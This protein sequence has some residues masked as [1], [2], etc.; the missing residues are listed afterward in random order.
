MTKL[1][2]FAGVAL[3]ALTIGV[4]GCGDDDDPVAPT[5]TVTVPTPPTP[6]PPPLAATMSPDA[7]TIGVGGT[8]VFAV[9]VSG[10]VAGE[11]ASWTCASSD[12]SKA[13]VSVIPVGCQATAVAVGGT[14]ITA[15][16]TKGGETTNAGAGLTITEDMVESAFMALALIEDSDDDAEVL[17]G[18]VSVT[19]NVERGD[20]TLM[21]LSVL[22]DGVVA[23][24]LPF[25]DI[26]AVA[27]PQD[28][29]AQQQAVHAFVLSFN[30]AEY[31]A[32]TGEPAY[33]NGERT[34]SAEL[35]VAGKDEPYRSGAHARE[36]DNDDGYVVMADLGDNSEI[37]D[38][39][40][41]W[42]GGPDNGTIDI[43]A[44]PVSYSG[45]SVTT[46]SANFCGKDLTDS[47]GADGYT[48]EFAC[49]DRESNTDAEV[50]LVG[51]MLTLSSPGEAGVILNDDHPFP[52][53]VDFMGPSESP[54]I[55]ANRNGREDGWLNAAVALTGEV[56]A[57][58]D[59]DENWLVDG[60]DE[61]G[62]IGGY[63]TMLRIG[64]DLEAALEASPGS[65]LPAESE[66][67]DSY[68]AVAS[69]TDDL[70]NMSELPDDDATC[71][72][73]PA[74]GDALVD[75]DNDMMTA[76]VYG[77]DETPDD[78]TDAVDDLSGQ[79]LEFGVDTT[80]PTIEFDDGPEDEGRYNDVTS[81]PSG[82][83]NGTAFIVDDDESDVGNSGLS[84][85]DDATPVMVTVRRRG[86]N[87]EVV[88]PV[89]GDNGDVDNTNNDDDCEGMLLGQGTRLSFATPAVGSYMLD[90][91]VKDKAGNSA[92]ADPIAFVFDN[93][94]ARTT[95]PG[96]QGE[97][98]AGER[99]QM[100]ASL[101]DNLSI[102]DYYV[103]VNFGDQIEL[104]VGLPVPVDAIDAD[105]RMNRNHTVIVPAIGFGTPTPIMA[106][107]AGTQS[108]LGA[109]IV[110][111]SGVTVGVRDQ[112]QAEYTESTG[113]TFPTVMAPAEDKRFG[114]DADFTFALSVDN[115][116]VEGDADDCAVTD[117]PTTSDLE[118]VATRADGTFRVDPFERVDF[119]MQDVNG[120]HWLLGSDDS[121]ASG[122][123]DASDRTWTYSLNNVSG[124]MLYMMTRAAGFMDAA[125]DMYTVRAFAVNGDGVALMA[126]GEVVIDPD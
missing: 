87:N 18:K 84:E 11:A 72:V 53:F 109:N 38:D 125:D 55:V 119:W 46:V 96:V 42:Y 67:S 1:L 78:D 93:E 31:D 77:Y 112:T 123:N 4:F 19:L 107:Y 28:E 90:A 88:C 25:G 70:G 64:E 40:R 29:P 94:V 13:T 74:G 98:T 85:G 66:D 76:D 36:F 8:V 50:G 126:S 23:A 32:V 108:T 91:S 44:L 68:C 95:A 122:R 69:A 110:V 48:F 35:M 121:G 114:A 30:S 39:G 124:A 57:D 3:L 63:N 21:Q 34:I 99:F 22:V 59:D 56:D 106:P 102:R 27:A 2:R 65:A 115:V 118:F 52:A 10:G 12:P 58:E 14:S 16:V 60:A 41:Q 7:Q 20:E 80:D 5:V 117:E 75:H 81:I 86:T 82:N 105:P 6:P 103:T 104:G 37:G 73:A 113:G 71:R 54:I 116:C 43:T 33:M 51:D 100:V 45:G 97:V 89:I 49:E 9:S 83:T 24:I 61:T 101:N 47:D 17:S 79:T 15:V 111:I 26:S 92:S 120:Q 62:G